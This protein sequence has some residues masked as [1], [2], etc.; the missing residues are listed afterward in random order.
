M[1]ETRESLVFTFSRFHV[2][3]RSINFIR[4]EGLGYKFTSIWSLPVRTERTPTS[5]NY[6][7]IKQ[8][9]EDVFKVYL[10]RGMSVQHAAITANLD[11]CR[12]CG[13]AFYY[14]KIYQKLE[15]VYFP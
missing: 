10:G 5:V 11:M 7:D 15:G 3:F 13:L 6:T 4:Q 14:G 8:E 2:F 1:K 12:H 9:L